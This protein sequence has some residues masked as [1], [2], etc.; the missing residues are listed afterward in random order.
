MVVDKTGLILVV[1]ISASAVEADRILAAYITDRPTTPHMADCGSSHSQRITRGRQARVLG[2]HPRAIRHYVGGFRSKEHRSVGNTMTPW[3]KRPAS[4]L[5]P[6]PHTIAESKWS[7]AD[8]ASIRRLTVCV[9]L[10]PC[11]MRP[12]GTL[13][14]ASRSR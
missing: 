11:L 13:L 8:E 1:A 7:V 12:P 3:S 2:N 5:A 6:L 4:Q 9:S 10:P 14:A